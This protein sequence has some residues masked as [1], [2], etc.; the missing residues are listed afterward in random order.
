MARG[1][2]GLTVR[3]CLDG[4]PGGDRHR[5]QAGR[6][7]EA[8]PFGRLGPCVH[9][10]TDQRRIVKPGHRQRRAT[11]WLRVFSFPFQDE[12]AAASLVVTD[13]NRI[14][15]RPKRHRLLQIFDTRT[16]QEHDLRRQHFGGVRLLAL[17]AGTDHH[18]R[19]RRPIDRRAG[20]EVIA[21]S[22]LFGRVFGFVQ[23]SGAPAEA[24]EMVGDVLF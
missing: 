7:G 20:P 13:E 10:E 14:R 11:G 4:S 9:V 19:L 21:A 6:R 16:V 18:V 15:A 24:K 2:H 22:R 1:T 17:L 12:V 3:P 8:K 5:S 23:R